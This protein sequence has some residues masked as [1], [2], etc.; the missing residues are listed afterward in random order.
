M[1]PLVLFFT[2]DKLLVQGSWLDYGM[3]LE[4]VM[5]AARGLGLDTCPQAA[6][7][8]FHQV[9]RDVLEI[10]DSEEVVCGMALGYAD[11][12]AIENTLI[13][14]REPVSGFAEFHGF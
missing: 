7:V 14:E 10:P 8:H 1:R 4:N 6:W 11:E 5:I 12:T 13:T 3:F 9:V 2:I